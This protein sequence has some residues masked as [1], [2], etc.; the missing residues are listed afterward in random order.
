MPAAGGAVN[1]NTTDTPTKIHIAA[2][3]IIIYPVLDILSINN[4]KWVIYNFSLN[5]AKLVCDKT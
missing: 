1:G 4:S 2:K 5:I 3:A